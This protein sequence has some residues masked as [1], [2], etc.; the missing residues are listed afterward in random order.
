M[1]AGTT[2]GFSDLQRVDLVG[3]QRLFLSS[4]EVFKRDQVQSGALDTKHKWV[5]LN[6]FFLLGSMIKMFF[7]H[8]SE[9]LYVT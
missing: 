9:G 3:V 7:D 8:I 5:P 2:K 1:P 4:M 6:S